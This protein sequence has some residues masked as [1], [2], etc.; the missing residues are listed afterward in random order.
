MSLASAL[1]ISLSGIQAT[2]TQL[3]L[4]ASNISNAATTGYTTKK[5]TLS[6][7]TLGSV[8]GGVNVV[9][10]TRA[11]NSALY[12][13]LTKATSS[14][15]LRSTQND[16]LQQI[17]DILGTSASDSPTLTASLS[18]FINAWKELAASPESLVAKRQVVQDASTFADEVQ[19][20]ASETESLDRQC[21]NDISSTVSD[22][23]SYLG[24]IKD[25]NHK[26]S[27]A[28]TANLSS[29]DLQDQ[30]DQLILKVSELTGVTVLA[31]DFGQI[32]LYTATGYQLVDG[33][34]ARTFTYDGTNIT[35][36]ANTT[37]SLN[38]ALSGGKLD[39]LVNFR[40]TAVTVSTDPATNVI[41]KMRSQL[42][43]IVSAFTVLT[44]SA[45]SGEVSFA[46]AYNSLPDV[47]FATTTLTNALAFT[48]INSG[49]LGNSITIT[50]DDD[51]VNVGNYMATITNGTTTEV[52]NNLSDGVVPGT[53]DLWTNLAA[54]ITA[55]PSTLVASAIDGTGNLDPT[56]LTLP[57]A[58]AYQLSG[59]HSIIVPVQAGELAADFFTGTDRTTFAVNASLL[60]G[61]A[62]AKAAAAPLV[63]DT[64]L[65]STRVFTADGLS[66]ASSNYSSLATSSLTSFQQAANNISTLN[67]T[68][69]D[70]RAYLEERYTNETGVN[71]DNE[72]V[73]LTTLQNAYAASAHVMSVVKE[74]FT[75]L[76]QLL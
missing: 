55:A 32:A 48:A 11:E 42:D 47:T 15:S 2:S 43:T 29:G 26:I 41:Q 19:R 18:K 74:L 8:G 65:D 70:A 10:F 72:L 35:S 27:Q 58:P 16:Y 17:Q 54:A 52:Y 12:T 34:S 30:R 49:S 75:T 69:E 60:N 5:A 56:T 33:S 63:T 51:P 25:L 20:I 31:R 14:A 13:T 46:T 40:A 6:P 9:G 59:G 1:T 28:T 57:S 4:T 62:T 37:L 39:A 76:E 22:L 67:T 24:Q 50:L 68:A 61:T 23:N 7:A 53:H 71:V 3:E 73:N 36:T 45:T 21:S 66:V 44:T 64:L 38:S